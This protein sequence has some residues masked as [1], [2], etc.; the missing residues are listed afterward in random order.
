MNDKHVD[1]GVITKNSKDIDAT[2]N[3]HRNECE[4]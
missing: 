2:E 4:I 3:E 1:D